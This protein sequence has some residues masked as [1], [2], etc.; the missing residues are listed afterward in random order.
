MTRAFGQ[1]GGRVAHRLG[2]AF[3]LLTLLIALCGASTL[4]GAL[5]LESQ[6]DRITDQVL[7]A[8][9][10]NVRL[11][12]AG[13]SAQRSMRGY[14]V[15]GDRSELA[16]FR[17]ARESIAS[18]SGD[19]RAHK[20]LD[21]EDLTTQQRQIEAYLRVAD[22]QAKTTPGSARAVTLTR[23]ASQRFNAFEVTNA[24]LDERMS[25]EEQRLED[26]ADT[27]IRA[28]IAGF[29]TALVAALA[30]AVYTSVHTTRALTGPLRRT[31]RTLGRLTAGDHA[32]RAEVTGPEEIRAVARS[33]NLLADQRDRLRAVELERQRLSTVAKE[34]GIRIRDRLDVGY[35]LDEACNGIG[36]V[37]A[38]DY[39]FILLA[40]DGGSGFPLARVWSAERGLLSDDERR[41]IPT[42]PA[43]VVRDHYR[44]GTPWLA[45]DLSQYV[46]DTRPMPGAPGSFG[47]TGMPAENRA[48]AAALGLDSAVIIPIGVGEEPIGAVSVARTSA[49][50]P[51]RPVDVEFAESMAGGVG[52]ALHTALLYEKESGLVDKLRALDKAK[53]D[54]LSTVSHELRTPLTSIVGYIELLKDEDTDPLS[55]SQLRMLD[56]V[57]RNA[58]RLRAL[59]ED[60]LTLSRIESGAFSSYKAPIDLRQLVT[61]AADAMRPAAEA[62]SVGLETYCPEQPLVLEADGEQLDRVLMN[63]LSNA[64]KF[65]RGGGTVSV[66]A[67]AQDGEAVLSVSDTGIGI[68]AAEQE[69]LFQRFFRASNATEQAI[70]GTGLGL[71]IVHTI[72]ANHGG[73]TQVRSEEGRGTTITTWL[74]LSGTDGAADSA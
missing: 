3:G 74:P 34:T 60:L 18:I 58:N 11:L 36:E 29:G 65:T 19:V 28:G 40:E 63:L 20:V 49:D 44:R 24:R 46:S 30:L 55:P 56:V 23:E 10:D 73:R 5:A 25:E 45:T 38:A 41:G 39:V 31:E 2:L 32:A 1:D 17:A 16:A 57:D 37:L 64:V 59:I 54:F 67:D 53:S 35:V 12:N 52:R 71:T 7:P 66:R 61:S 22:D 72:V 42:L 15:T 8:Q 9:D 33:V 6:R 21:E 62:A 13:I 50:R 47:K 14:L 27:A 69:K 43:D 4:I 51:W 48:A 68:P 70:P 26:R